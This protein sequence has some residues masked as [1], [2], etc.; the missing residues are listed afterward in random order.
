MLALSDGP[1][2]CDLTYC[3]VWCRFRMI[4]RYLVYRP[5]EVVRIC[6]LL[7]RAME[8]CPGHGPVHLLVDSAVE[9]PACFGGF[10]LDCLS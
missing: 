10:G 5:E 3:I 6:H 2:E 4:R 1:Q 8:G 7:D 9:A